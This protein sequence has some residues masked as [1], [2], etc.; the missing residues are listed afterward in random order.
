MMAAHEVVAKSRNDRR[1]GVS[2]FLIAA[3]TLIYISNKAVPF[4]FG[5]GYVQP[6]NDIHAPLAEPECRFKLS[7]HGVDM[8]GRMQ[9]L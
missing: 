4:K 3:E 8:D 2:R 1:K 5:D 6:A 9:D 7:G